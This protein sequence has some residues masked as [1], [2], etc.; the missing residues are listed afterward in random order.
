MELRVLGPIEVLT[1]DG[2]VRLGKRQ[3]RLILGILGM[4][5]GRL[6]PAQR[7]IHLL[8]GDS[9]PSRPRAVLHS[10]ISELRAALTESN[11][12]R[13][14]GWLVTDGDGYVLRIEP[15]MVDAH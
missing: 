14:Q 9:P 6:V 5:A 8:W 2:P 13:R 7:L 1:E 12:G 15:A 3:H 10:R 4:E 11:A